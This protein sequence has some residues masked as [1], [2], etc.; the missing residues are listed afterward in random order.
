MNLVKTVRSAV[1]TGNVILGTKETLSAVLSG[2]VKFVVVTSNCDRAARE[3]LARY[4]KLSG[5]EVHEFEG[6]SVELGEVCG[7][8]FVISMLAVPGGGDSKPKIKRKS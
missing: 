1:D 7:K 5:V 2:D 4:S 8:P 3:D 6:S